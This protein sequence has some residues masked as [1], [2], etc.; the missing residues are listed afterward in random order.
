MMGESV[1]F[2]SL[3]VAAALLFGIWMD[4]HCACWFMAVMIEIAATLAGQ[5]ARARRKQ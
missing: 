4:S 1:F 3:Q 5:I 2:I